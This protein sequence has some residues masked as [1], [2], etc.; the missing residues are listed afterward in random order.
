MDIWGP[1]KSSIFDMNA[2]TVALLTYAASIII[3]FI[4]GISFVSWL[5]PIIFYFVESK[6]NF[7]K[8]HA[9]QAFLLNIS[10]IVIKFILS[11]FA[12]GNIIA[13]VFG[14]HSFF[15]WGN[16]AVVFIIRG[17]ISIV[18]TVFEVIAIIKSHDYVEYRIPVIGKLTDKI[19]KK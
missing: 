6:S 4:P 17:I 8:F 15:N 5:I 9:M 2:N 13:I 18:I 3:I 12:G 14:T 16:L 10:G 7:V 1:H 11:L 19:I